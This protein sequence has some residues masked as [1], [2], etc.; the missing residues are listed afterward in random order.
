MKIMVNGFWEEAP[1]G[2]TLARAIDLFEPGHP[3]LIAELNGRFVH[4]L[5][6]EKRFLASGDRLELILA[7]FGG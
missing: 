5:E 7:A 4:Y 6:Y 1:K 2:I 3:E